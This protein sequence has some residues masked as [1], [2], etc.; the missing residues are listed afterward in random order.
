MTFQKLLQTVANQL[1]AAANSPRFGVGLTIASFALLFYYYYGYTTDAGILGRDIS[2]ED[3]IYHIFFIACNILLHA[4]YYSIAT[5]HWQQL[6]IKYYIFFRFLAIAYR[7]VAW[8]FNLVLVWNTPVYL[9]MLLITV[10]ATRTSKTYG[11]KNAVNYRASYA[12]QLLRHRIFPRLGKVRASSHRDT[13][14]HPTDR[15]NTRRPQTQAAD[16][17]EAQDY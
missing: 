5:K 17:P 7:I 6:L 13:E 4:H 1:K 10:A 16:Q 2:A 9:A 12:F 14:T 15:G 8:S 11:A 3:H